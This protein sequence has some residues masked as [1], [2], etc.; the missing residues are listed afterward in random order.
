MARDEGWLAEHMLILKLTNPQ[1]E[2][3]Y[4][5]AAFPSACGKTNLA[6]LVPTIPGWK[7][8]TIGDD[9]CWMKFGADG[10][11]YA[12]NPEA[13]FFGVA[14]GTGYDTNPNAMRPSRGNSIFTNVRPHRRRRRVV[15]GHE[16]R[17][18]RRAPDRL[19]RQRLDARRPRRPPRIPNA[20]FTAPA[21][22][23]PSIASEWEDPA[24]RADL[25]DPVRRPPPH[26]GAAGHQATRL[27]ARRV[28][29]R[30]HGLA[31]PPLPQGAVGNLRAATRWRCCR[32]AATTWPT[33][34][35]TGCRSA[36]TTATREA[37]EDLLR[38]LVPPRRGRPLPVAGLRR[39]QPRAQVGV[40]APRPA[41]RRGRDPDRSA[42]DVT[43]LDV[44]TETGRHGRRVRRR[45]LE[46]AEMPHDRGVARPVRRQA[47]RGAE[48]GA[49]GSEAARRRLTIQEA[50]RSRAGHLSWV[51]GPRRLGARKPLRRRP[52][53][54]D[55]STRCSERFRGKPAVSRGRDAACRTSFPR[56]RPPSAPEPRD[57]RFGGTWP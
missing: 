30:D 18:R 35:A 53:F 26:D 32:S 46:E 4:I 5:A 31:R 36:S 41:G 45:G 16:R 38:Q 3:K 2:H 6:M 37:A 52:H 21:S 47:P 15:G 9:I 51:A 33:T 43:G 1:G 10:R 40:R 49:R 44:T 57:Q 19:A 29:R 24:G 23:C 56:R 17:P 42:L 22:Q 20:R 25:G 28:P 27:G 39:E 12:I 13:G 55:D 8:E 50:P 11:L 48:E 34:S 14:P 54:S 7:A